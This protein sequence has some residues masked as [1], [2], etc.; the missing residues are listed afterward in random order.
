[1]QDDETGGMVWL[2]AV[3]G[4]FDILVDG[5]LKIAD[6]QEPV[7]LV[8]EF[9][10]ESEERS[11][12]LFDTDL[13]LNK[14]KVDLIINGHAYAPN[15]EPAR[16][17]LTS[18]TIGEGADQYNKTLK[19]IGNRWWDRML[20]IYFKTD[21][22]PF[23]KMPITYENAWGGV[24]E[25]V[26]DTVTK[27]PVY[28]PANPAGKGF[29]AKWAHW[30]GKPL[31]NVEYPKHPTKRRKKSN[32]VAGY[33][34]VAYH[35]TPRA[36]WAG[37]YKDENYSKRPADFNPRFY[38]CAPEDQ[39]IPRE[40]LLGGEAF[41]LRNLTPNGRLKFNLPKVELSFNTY[42]ND[43]Y[44][45]HFGELHSIIIEPDFPRLLMIWQ[46]SLACDGLE[47]RLE[48]SFITHRMEYF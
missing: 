33:S 37:T 36:K 39:Q 9:K 29:A 44:V 16:E 1:M 48:D 46:T 43:K 19:V 38:N 41:S 42:L 13:V 12:L 35:W 30:K 14:P 10:G 34:A 18:V 28:L 47:D 5:S 27:E 45:R 7:H 21:P 22:E 2:V 3:K 40:A 4:T 25:K 8:P 24:D 6:E 26:I 15:G 32:S 31:P 23:T 17:V 20:G 11:S